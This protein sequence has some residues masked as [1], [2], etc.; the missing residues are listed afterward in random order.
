MR[1][2][3]VQMDYVHTMVDAARA[4]VAFSKAHYFREFNLLGRWVN[5]G[6]QASL[7]RSSNLRASY[8]G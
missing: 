5:R 4:L 6:A 7:A 8:G 3:I 1:I 2:A